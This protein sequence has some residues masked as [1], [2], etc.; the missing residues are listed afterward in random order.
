MKPILLLLS[1]ALLAPEWTDAQ[2]T[3]QGRK[4]RKRAGTSQST[5]ASDST[6]Y[7]RSQRTRTSTGR[8]SNENVTGVQAGVDT[9]RLND[10]GMN[11]NQ[12]ANNGTSL[13]PNDGGVTNQ[14]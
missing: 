2:G 11:R 1:L 9:V 14:Q 10:R 8:P 3:A 12:N 4:K 6:Y 5:T 13:P 7:F